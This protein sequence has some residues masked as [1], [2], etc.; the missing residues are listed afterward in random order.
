MFRSIQKTSTRQQHQDLQNALNKYQQV[1]NADFNT[2][3]RLIPAEEMWR[4]FV[5]GTT[6]INTR[7]LADIIFCMSDLSFRYHET[8]SK[9]DPAFAFI[10]EMTVRE[11]VARYD[12]KHRLHDSEFLAILRELE[13][14][15]VADR[16]MHD[17]SQVTIADLLT[18]D[19]AWLAYECNEPGYL[20][21][22]QKA[23]HL[24]L[25]LNK[26]FTVDDIV[27][28]Q[29]L[30][31]AGVEHTNYDVIPNERIGSFR[32]TIWQGYGFTPGVNS[33]VAGLQQVLQNMQQHQN[34]LITF[35][36]YEHEDRRGLFHLNPRTLQ[37]IKDNEPGNAGYAQYI[38]DL[39]VEEFNPEDPIDACF[40]KFRQLMHDMLHQ[41][42]STNE[43][44]H[45]VAN[46][47]MR[48][49]GFFS[50]FNHTNTAKDDIIMSAGYRSLILA[51]NMIANAIDHHAIQNNHPHVR[52]RMANIMEALLLNFNFE[53][54]AATNP[55]TRLRLIIQ[56]I[57]ECEQ[58]HPFTDFNCRIFCMTLLFNLLRMNGF[59]PAILD[60][61]NIFDLMSIDEIKEQVVAGMHRVF[62]LIDI[63]KTHNFD[64]TV[65]RHALA[66]STFLAAE[67]RHF[68]EFIAVEESYRQQLQPS[69]KVKSPHKLS[70]FNEEIRRK[71]MKEQDV[72]RQSHK[73]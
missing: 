62:E 15:S 65:V 34:F 12:I 66:K 51:E 43:I 27:K 33:S 25:T 11:F 56:Y 24:G 67:L 64:T 19:N 42:K 10:R 3:Y 14:D 31:G 4:F 49:R 1:A 22:M 2:L 38:A 18:L 50:L 23:L 32:N 72:N 57:Q 39:R 45:D 68:D 60:D 36:D 8:A 47:L 73:R 46:E 37:A 59:P 20:Q 58:L 55:D 28:L 5:D 41:Q 40:L 6:V 63:K 44:Y 35:D 16:I 30:C 70:F 7:G 54:S 53:L 71:T 21:A 61:P 9:N 17:D 29:K 13:F 69:S 48:Y 26:Y 52:A